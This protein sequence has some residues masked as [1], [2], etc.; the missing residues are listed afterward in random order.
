[1]TFVWTDPKSFATLTQLLMHRFYEFKKD[2]R[3]RILRFKLKLKSKG[4]FAYTHF[5]RHAKPALNLTFIPLPTCVGH[6]MS[7]CSSAVRRILWPVPAH[8]RTE[9]PRR[10]VVRDGDGRGD[11]FSCHY[12][13]ES[14]PAFLVLGLWHGL[15]RASS[16]DERGS[17]NSSYDMLGRSVPRFWGM[18]RG[19]FEDQISLFD[20]DAGA[21]VRRDGFF[22][23]FGG[24]GVR[25]EQ[26]ALPLWFTTRIPRPD[27]LRPRAA[28]V[29]D[30]PCKVCAEAPASPAG[31]LIGPQWVK[32]KVETISALC[33]RKEGVNLTWRPLP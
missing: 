21:V 28:R 2:R 8:G 14:E 27:Q 23:V 20:D 13:P 26:S 12:H 30:L 17:D 4:Y 22:V 33:D 6:V 16:C 1:M 25:R 18:N 11:G 29:A 15:G 10:P 31:T 32:A 3:K 24:Q 7:A 5:L 19:Y 9:P